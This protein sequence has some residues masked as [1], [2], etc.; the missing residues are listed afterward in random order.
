MN[1]N[2]T[3]TLDITGASSDGSGIARLPDG[4]VTF[5][6]NALPGETVTARLLKV[7]KRS[8]WAKTLTVLSA[9][10]E[11]VEPDCPHFPQCGGC[12]YR[13]MTY[14]EELRQKLQR[15]NDAFERIAK[16]DLRANEILPA[17]SRSGYRNKA[18]Y[19]I[20]ERKVGFYQ[21]RSHRL[22]PVTDCLLQT[23]FANAAAAALQSAIDELGLS[24]YDE[25]TQ[26]GLLRKLFV[27]GSQIVIIAKGKPKLELAE[28]L[29]SKL[30]VCTSLVWCDNRDSGNTIFG[31]GTFYTL[32]G[33]ATVPMTLGDMTFDV[34]PASFF[35]VNSKQTEV[36]YE[37]AVDF[38]KSDSSQKLLELY[39]GIGTLTAYL[40]PNCANITGLDI[41]PAAIDNAVANHKKLSIENSN[42]ITGDAAQLY[43][44][45]TDNYS[46]VIVDPPRKGLDDAVTKAVAN[47]KP[48]KIIY[49]SCD[50]ATAARDTERLAALGYNAVKIIGVDMFPGTAHVEIVIKYVK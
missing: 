17:Q 25:A 26:K 49:I 5:V 8:V 15:V 44:L 42:F 4:R 45:A 33:G 23:E 10:P 12:S 20:A 24:T 43:A 22:L 30:S 39:C 29:L 38:V 48:N 46:A 13:H 31:N 32:H 14:A 3:V 27:R 21:A 47:L 34:F 36:L 18:I 2:D 16:S 9:S 41:V 50:P 11:R 7:D 35:Q 6:A 19:N 37:Q 40:A 28:F 1:K